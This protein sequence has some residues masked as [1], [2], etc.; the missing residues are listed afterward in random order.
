MISQDLTSNHKYQHALQRLATKPLASPMDAQEDLLA[1]GDGLI[2]QDFI[3]DLDQFEGIAL[4]KACYVVQY[5]STTWNVEPEQRKN[6]TQ[7]LDA[8]MH[9]IESTKPSTFYT[10]DKPS[11][12]DRLAIHWGLANGMKPSRVPGLL[13][14]QRRYNNVDRLHLL[15]DEH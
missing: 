15:A 13:D 6:L 7:L 11:K 8:A 10:N 12:R 4:R 14:Q 2:R 3:P 9:R 5:F 1:L